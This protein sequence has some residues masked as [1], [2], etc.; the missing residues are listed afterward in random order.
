M[1]I[2]WPKPIFHLADEPIPVQA[3]SWSLTAGV[4]PYRT[5]VKVPRE[6]S[7][8]LSAKSNPVEIGCYFHGGTEGNPDLVDRRF[9]RV[10]LL[11]PKPVDDFFV[12]WTLADSRFS[13]RGKKITGSWNKTRT[14]NS[15]STP[16]A[17]LPETAP[18]RVRQQFDRFSQGRYL[19][20]SVQADGRPWDAIQILEQ[21]LASLSIPF[22][23]AVS[24]DGA[25]Y[26]ENVEFDEVDV[27]QALAD[28]LAKS[29]LQLGIRETGDVYVFSL[30]VFDPSLSA[31][32]LAAQARLKTGPGK[33]YRQ[34]KKNIRPSRIHVRFE[35]KEEIRVVATTNTGDYWAEN[36]RL[37][38]Y[39]LPGVWTQDDVFWGR[40]IACENVIPVPYPITVG[41][42]TANVGEYM[43][44]RQFMA[45][46]PVPIAETD[47]R[48]RFFSGLLETWYAYQISSTY[49]IE[50]YAYASQICGALRQ[51]YRQT[52]R[53]DPFWVQRMK[54][55]EPRRASVLDAYSG[56]CPPSPV[57]SD[58]CVIP[59]GR[60]P[61]FSRNPGLGARAAF[62]WLVED[63]DP[64]RT[65]PTIGTLQTVSEPFGIF[66]VA[67]PSLIDGVWGRVVFT[68]LDPLPELSLAGS[69]PVMVEQ[70]HLRSSHVF[71]TI[72]SV[73]WATAWNGLYS[74]VRKYETVSLDY[75]ALGGGGPEIA[76]LSRLEYARAAA[77]E[78]SPDGQRIRESG[79][80]VNSDI[81]SALASAEG[82][83]LMNQYNDRVA[84]SVSLAGW[85][86]DGDL[87]GNVRSITYS[88]TPQRGAETVYDLFETLP[89]PTI[90]QQMTQDQINYLYRHVARA[91]S[92]SEMGGSR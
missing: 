88:F 71:E 37:S 78:V 44:I 83:K 33:L 74:D 25:Y 12:H 23:P 40:V 26:V 6:T 69:T 35:R 67:L 15:Y 73:V 11:E 20:W 43:P 80:L 51:H 10:H 92:R 54:S 18:A 77:S 13:W 21:V 68:G 9:Q 7:L 42:R 56:Y 3:F 19:P 52:W 1:T 39:V 5:S 8:R 75:S 28:L 50:E 32:L 58:Y 4:T 46:L 66:R 30:D 65:Q 49:S 87:T 22:V 62:N 60:V 34:E 84:G 14:A 53:M 55:W 89:D 31:N 47:L 79:V 24:H 16:L 76:Y 27:H 57:F 86:S 29:R 41:G 59:T 64:Y 70:S 48:E 90:Q 17:A 91:D 61:R 38:A 2:S 72:I 45:N 85:R 63:R 36:S 82:A 81:L